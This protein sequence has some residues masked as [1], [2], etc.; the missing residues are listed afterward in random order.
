M[1]VPK[2]VWGRGLKLPRKAELSA[3]RGSCRRIVRKPQ[4]ASPGLFALM[5]GHTANLHFKAGAEASNALWRALRRRFVTWQPG[6]QLGAW[7]GEVRQWGWDLQWEETKPWRWQHWHT[8]HMDWLHEG[9]EGI[10]HKLRESWR[11]GMLQDFPQQSR[12]DSAKLVGTPYDPRVIKKAQDAFFPLWQS[13]MEGDLNWQWP[14]RV[15]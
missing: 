9:V 12:W 1:V 2:A 5:E 6:I 13:F 8:G 3:W 11:V 10:K 4:Q 15:S 14:C 7:V